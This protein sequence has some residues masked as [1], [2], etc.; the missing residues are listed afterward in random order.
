L[1]S[2]ALDLVFHAISDP[3]RRK[4][5]A[6]LSAGEQALG[7]L[8]EPHSMSLP[9]FSKHIR[10]LERAGLVRTEK[11]GRTHY[12]TLQAEPLRAAT[13]W[14]TFYQRHWESNLDALDAF[15]RENP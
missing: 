15:L 11:R 13:E 5:L 14:L 7:A 4:V 3:T 2:P 6:R 1:N 12:C 8:A 10:V 9:A